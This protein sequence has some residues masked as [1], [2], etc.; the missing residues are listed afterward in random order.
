MMPELRVMDGPT[1]AGLR[2]RI[3]SSLKLA[4]RRSSGSST[5]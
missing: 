4:L 1:S 5:R 3:D 2:V